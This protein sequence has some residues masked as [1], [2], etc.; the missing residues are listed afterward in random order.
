GDI[1]RRTET[2]ALCQYFWLSSPIS[3]VNYSEQ[4][5]TQKIRATSGVYSR[6]R[7]CHAQPRRLFTRTPLYLLTDNK[8]R[9]QTALTQLET[10]NHPDNTTPVVVMIP[11]Q[12]PN[13]ATIICGAFTRAV[14][15][16]ETCQNLTFRH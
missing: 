6:E 5:F 3:A 14:C 8:E 4:L 16:R 13:D 12:I 11:P 9:K 1:L 7:H 2:N 15:S 10:R